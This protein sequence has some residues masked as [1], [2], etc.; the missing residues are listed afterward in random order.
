MLRRV[1][2]EFRQRVQ[3]HIHRAMQQFNTKIY[4]DEAAAYGRI[5]MQDYLSPILLARVCRENSAGNRSLTA[6]YTCRC[7]NGFF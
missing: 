1:Y 5:A 7:F 2:P 6:R 4:R 3:H